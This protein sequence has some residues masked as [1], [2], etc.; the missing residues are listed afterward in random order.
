METFKQIRPL[1]FFIFQSF[2][3]EFIEHI[4]LNARVP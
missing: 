2:R 1:P 3:I 4:N